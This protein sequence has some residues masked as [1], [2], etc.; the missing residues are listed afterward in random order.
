LN[1][2]LKTISAGYNHALAAR[3]S[4]LSGVDD[5]ARPTAA[6]AIRL[7]PNVPN[8]FNPATTI[9]YELP[10]PGPVRLCVYDLRG[11]LV[12]TLVDGQR[13]T[14]LHR[15]RWDGTDDR[16]RPQAAGVYLCLLAAGEVRET[17]RL[18]LVN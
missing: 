8:P 1:A 9:T 2:G 17:R 7:W 15:I 5:E 12:R 4:I 10:A 14:G 18:T 13:E 3:S 11:R 16:G 6:A